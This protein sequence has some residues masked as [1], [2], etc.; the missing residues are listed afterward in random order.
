MS[1]QHLED[2]YEL[3]PAQQG[4]LFHTLYAPQSGV[5]VDQIRFTLEGEIDPDTLERAWQGVMDRHPVLRTSF[6]WEDMEKPLQA[7]H[8]RVRPSVACHDLRDLPSADQDEGIERHRE[9]ERRRGFA[10]HEP[11]LMR[12]AMFRTAA[13]RWRCVWTYHHLLL[14]GWSAAL[15]LRR[16]LAA[17]A[18][19]AR[20]AAPAPAQG[21]PYV[22]YI[23][24][25]QR[26]DLSLAESFWRAELKG[27]TG[28]AVAA[29][30]TDPTRCPDV[31]AGVD[32]HERV[33]ALSEED[34]LELQSWVR[35]HRFTVSTVVQGAWALVLS[36]GGSGQDV[37]FG[38]TVSGRPPSLSG[39]E[40]M[41]GLFMNTLPVRVRVPP[42][43]GVLAWL[44]ELQ[45]RQAV[46]RDYEHSPLVQVNGWSE[47]PRG[48]PLFESLLVL[49]NYPVED[50]AS[51]QESTRVRDVA[52]A[53]RTNYPVTV[54]VSLGRQLSIELSYDRGR[55]DDGAAER[56]LE[57]LVVA[58]KGLVEDPER[59]LEEVPVMSVAERH[60]VLEEWN[61]TSFEVSGVGVHELIEAQARRTP[62]TEAL[63][64]ERESLTYAEVDEKASHL[65]RR[66]MAMGVGPEVRVGLCLGRSWRLVVGI[67]GILKAGGAYVPLDGSEPA[68]RLRFVVADAGVAVVVTEGSLWEG[69]K[70]PGVTVVRWGEEDTGATEDVPPHP[71]PHVVPSNLA[72]VLYTSGSTGEP[73]GVAVSHEAVVNCLR[74]VSHQ[75]GSA[76]GGR[77]LA[78]TPLTFDIATLELLLPLA[79]G[80]CV[81][82]GS[83]EALTDGMQLWRELEESKATT[84]QATPATWRGLVQAGWKGGSDLVRLCGGDALT[85]ELARDLCSGGET[86]WQ[87]YGPSE[88]TIWA[89]VGRVAP[90][91]GSWRVALGRP[92]PNTRLY[93]LDE[94]QQPVPLGVAGELYIGGRGLARGYVGRPAV[95]AGHFVPDSLSGES[96][97]RLYRTGDRVR[98]REDGQL[99]FL[100]RLDHQVKVRG[101]RVEP[102]EIEGVLRGHPTVEDA[103]VVSRAE[104]GGEPQ[105]VAYVRAVSGATADV[106]GLWDWLREH[107]PRALVPSSVVAVESW[108]LTAHGKLDRHALPAPVALEAG[109]AEPRHPVEEVIAG[110]W[111]EVL[112]L[113]RV[114]IHDDFFALGGHSLLA[115]QVISRLR[116]AFHVDL[117]VARMFDH[118]TVA[119]LA[120]LTEDARRPD[121]GGLM[122]VEPVPRD[123]DQPL[124]F[125]QQ[126]LWLLDQLEPG[127]P[128]HTVLMAMRL[129]G[130]LD[131]AALEHA[132]AVL[133][134]R[135]DIL[136]TTFPTVAGRPI[137]VIGDPDPPVL[138]AVDLAALPERSRDAVTQEL[139]LRE[140]RRP[141]VLS[142]GPLVRFV[143]FRLLHDE[144]VLLFT[145]HHIV[146]DGPSTSL[147]VQEVAAH[148][149]AYKE[150]RLS[151]IAQPRIQYADFASWQQHERQGRVTE[152]RARYWHEQLGGAVPVGFPA[153]RA[154]RA[155]PSESRGATWPVRLPSELTQAL[156]V[157]ARREGVTL[158]I[159]L[160]AAVQAL[161]YRLTGEDDVVVAAPLAHRERVETEGVIGPFLS[162]LPLRASLA[163]NPTFVE[164]LGRVRE[165]ALGAYEHQDLPFEEVL[166]QIAREGGPAPRS[167]FQVLFAFQGKAVAPRTPSGLTMVPV[168]IHNHTAMFDWSLFLVENLDDQ[169]SGCVEYNTG[170]FD[171]E[172]IQTHVRKLLLLL[173]TAVADPERRL[174]TLD[175]HATHENAAWASG[176]VATEP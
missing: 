163:D 168:T 88:A 63:R 111:A 112:G 38:M 44:K 156:K 27:F 42:K 92:L 155:I 47:V 162:T 35:T 106:R 122:P 5:Y 6:F 164:L 142:Q 48:T 25:L 143:L 53:T 107:L 61:A 98:Y 73:K 123:R 130:R 128:A 17:Y 68:E 167:W 7:V 132:V 136:R 85:R 109:S 129:G 78:V 139:A 174:D 60:R 154:P 26:Q 138:L 148:Y 149:D 99:E 58:L 43:A 144:H 131:V 145:A 3:S 69:V 90:E 160:L 133:L 65:A 127:N 10:L 13:R 23:A 102:G 165:A 125:G 110:I 108:P 64:W 20:G 114:G 30:Q 9:A 79:V 57:H 80:G 15:V 87:L 51:D 93:V 81:V 75:W 117:P 34:T 22:D 118:P 169:V 11:P 103:V 76:A 56:M 49:E 152:A 96:G 161:L 77:W 39:I 28:Q 176:A 70:A 120:R 147:L 91:E 115:T 66:L 95:T 157:L 113:E 124:S 82:V 62:E 126:R 52:Y 172:T 50:I 105:L 74:G 12:L 100:G 171:H 19:L 72:Y 153:D 24:W 119:R 41:V 16:A 83:E 84:L 45:V 32:V 8:R 170:V 97:A 121:W 94:R 46:L 4:I 33:I 59:L 150:G 175:I 1:R 2:L 55:V 141:F 137:Q 158:F 89:V 151:E 29:L 146:L 135:H 104:E 134:R 40:S 71:A 14:D 21:R 101:R 18:A 166:E 67:L 54:R 140:A 37:L 86:L 36:R 159:A 31:A 173:R 116:V